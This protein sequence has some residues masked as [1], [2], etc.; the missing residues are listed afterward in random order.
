MKRRLFVISS[1]VIFIFKG[2]SIEPLKIDVILEEN[3][4][5]EEN[6]QVGDGEYSRI[7]NDTIYTFLCLN[8]DTTSIYRAFDRLY[9]IFFEEKSLKNILCK[10]TFRI[11]EL[12]LVDSLLSFE[13]N[14]KKT[15]QSY[16]YVLY[17]KSLFPYMSEDNNE[18]LMVSGYI[19]YAGM[20]N[21]VFPLVYDES[22]DFFLAKINITKK[23]LVFIK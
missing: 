11:D 5:D 3:I 23:K 18:I 22:I 17:S 19:R 2:Y 13:F 15:K 20:E 16:D 8:Y 4:L 9:P 7:I 21:D 12:C 10:R 6:V 1:I 14:N